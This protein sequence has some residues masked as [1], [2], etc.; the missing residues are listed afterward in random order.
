MLRS[1]VHFLA[2]QIFLEPFINDAA[3]DMDGTTGA[4]VA[5]CGASPRCIGRRVHLLSGIVYVSESISLDVVS[6]V[7]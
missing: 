3:D 1:V 5:E 4:V 2:R 7:E 6:E